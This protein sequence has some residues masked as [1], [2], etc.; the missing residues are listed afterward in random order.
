MFKLP[1]K[2]DELGNVKDAVRHPVL[3]SLVLPASTYFETLGCQDAR[4]ATGHLFFEATVSQSSGS[5]LGTNPSHA[6]LADKPE[7]GK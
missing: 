5:V 3:C 6:I 4:A 2:R 1:S 7:E